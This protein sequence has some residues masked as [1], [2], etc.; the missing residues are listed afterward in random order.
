MLIIQIKTL[1]HTSSAIVDLIDL[2]NSSVAICL[3]YGWDAT[4]QV[5]HILKVQF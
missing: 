4:T 3:E 5:G 1:L 2:Q